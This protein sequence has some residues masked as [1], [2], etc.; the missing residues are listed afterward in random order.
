M[1]IKMVQ[2]FSFLYVCVCGGERVA[3]LISPLNW[4][5]LW[6]GASLTFMW[7]TKQQQKHQNPNPILKSK[8]TVISHQISSSS[9]YIWNSAHELPLPREAQPSGPAQVAGGH[10]ASRQGFSFSRPAKVH[11]APFS[12]EKRRHRLI[13]FPQL[14]L[15]P[16]I[17][18]AN[19]QAG[20][21]IDSPFRKFNLKPFIYWFIEC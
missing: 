5:L 4:L 14:E 10:M 6:I 20:K 16:C 11:R 3:N 17:T 8:T 7:T 12:T 1:S 21:V 2:Q 18:A 9:T 13:S 19:K 15:N